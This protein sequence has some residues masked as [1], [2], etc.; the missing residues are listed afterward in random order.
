MSELKHFTSWLMSPL[1]V[2]IAFGSFFG[3][4]LADDTDDDRIIGTVLDGLDPLGQFE[5]GNVKVFADLEAADVHF[6]KLGQVLRQA[7][8]VDF[9]Q[10][11][12]HQA[13]RQLDAGGDVFVD[14]V[15]RHLDVQF[16]GGVD[17]LEIH[18]Q[19]QGLVGMHLGVAKQDLFLLAVDDEVEDGRVEGFLLQSEEQAVVVQF[20]GQRS[21]RSAIDDARYF[22]GTAQAAARTRSLQRALLRVE[23]KL[24]DD[25]RVESCSATRAGG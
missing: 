13:A 4:T 21:G 8:N 9:G 19:D 18:M 22:A 14:E 17:P 10:D 23:F 24:H 11:V 6:D 20:D 12:V 3:A 16:V 2:V 7:V 25:S 5:L 1:W 15:E